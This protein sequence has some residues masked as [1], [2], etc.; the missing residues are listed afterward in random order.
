[1][2]RRLCLGGGLLL[3]LGLVAL[4]TDGL[5]QEQG[6]A[7]RVVQQD[8]VVAGGPKDFLEARHVVLKGSNE[9]IG[10][11]LATLAR[12]RHQ[13]KLLPS[14][15]RFRTRVQRR[16]FQEHYPI[17]FERMRG[18]ASAFGQRL[19]DDAQNFS[20]LGYLASLRFG[21]SVVHYPPGTTATGAGIVSRNYDFST[22]TLMGNRPR[23]GELP[24]TARPYLIEMHPD[25]GYASLALYSYDLLSG[26]LD[27]INSEGLTVALLAD[28]E[29]MAK[30]PLEPA[31]QDAVGL[32]VLQTLRLLLDTC[33]DVGEAKQALLLTKQYYE[34]I[35]VH[36]LVADRH[37]K[38]F[39]WEYSHTRNREHIIEDP[40]KPLITTNFSLHRHLEGKGPPSAKAA[41]DVCPRYCALAER[42]A[43]QSGKLT[44]GFI[45]ESHRAVDMVRPAP[46]GG[47]RAPVRTLWHAL[48]FP[49]ERKVQ[50]SFYLRD[51]AD[52][53]RPD[54]IRVARTD[55]LEFRLGSATAAK[56]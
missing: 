37:G 36:Y 48:Y 39:V 7:R 49:A 22:G 34:A 42:I 45:K 8:R 44:V 3:A 31:G 35:P 14:S 23:P 33:A 21:C 43:G 41:K 27:G 55:Y 11:A 30:F 24:A 12:E 26:V 10:R 5:T 20:V 53:D 16:Y 46:K 15:D 51:E 1:M 38:A 29:L 18:V 56:E 40:G 13:V 2:H 52:P 47:A 28:D 50:V 9:D 25:R 6:A 4:P 19:E 17:L 54:Q 32:G